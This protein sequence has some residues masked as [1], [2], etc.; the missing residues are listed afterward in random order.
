MSDKIAYKPNLAV[1]IAHRFPRFDYHFG[2]ADNVFEFGNIQYYEGAAFIPSVTLITVA[3]S[4]FIYHF[5]CC[6][7][8][9]KS[10]KCADYDHIEDD[11]TEIEY[12]IAKYIAL[13]R[14]IAIGFFIS[15]IVLMLLSNNFVFIFGDMQISN[16]IDALNTAFDSIRF[17][18]NQN[19]VLLSNYTTNSANYAVVLDDSSHINHC[20][21]VHNVVDQLRE[22]SNNT[23]PIL[24]QLHQLNQYVQD[25][26]TLS[27]IYLNNNNREYYMLRLYLGGYA[28]VLL[29]LVAGCCRTNKGY[30]KI[31][32]TITGCIVLGLT[33]CSCS[34]LAI[35]VSYICA[36]I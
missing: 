5:I 29:Y 36:C 35:L 16:G 3:I 6:C 13:K 14:R 23:N 18:I 22:M 1:S 20:T 7:L 11:I 32:I 15:L 34:I 24:Q 19:Q 31:I 2:H 12:K 27:D 9:C 33:I 28:V 8:C 26:Q 4:L 25:I 17:N 30:P 21:Q 10:L